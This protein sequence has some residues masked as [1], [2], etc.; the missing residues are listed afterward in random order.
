MYWGEIHGNPVDQRDPAWDRSRLVVPVSAVSARERRSCTS[1]EPRSTRDGNTSDAVYWFC[2]KHKGHGVVAGKGV[3]SGEIFRAAAN[4][5]GPVVEGGQVR[6]A[7]VPRWDREMQRP[8]HRFRRTRRL[9]LSE[10]RDGS[11]ITGNGP[12][13]MHWYRGIRGDYS[14]RSYPEVKAPLKGRPRSRLYWQI[15]AGVRNEGLDCEIRPA[16]LAQAED[17]P[18]DREAQW[19]AI[20]Q[21]QRQPDLVG[22]VAGE[23]SAIR[24][25]WPSSEHYPDPEPPTSTSRLDKLAGAVQK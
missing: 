23:F 10:K 18:H 1:R 16:R 20:E 15:E 13:R 25:I 22:R 12:G 21:R 11:V 9:R 8:D 3:E 6:S 17:Q 2:R 24:A 4:R 5:P 7:D 19:S 14:A